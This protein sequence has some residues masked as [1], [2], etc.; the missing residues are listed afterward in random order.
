MKTRIIVDAMGGD[1][2]PFSMVKGAVDGALAYGADLIFVGNKPEIEEILKT[3]PTSSLDIKV[4]HTD[5]WVE[6]SDPPT[7]V[8][9]EKRDSSVAISCDLLNDGEGDVLISSGNTGALFTAATL[10][11]RKLK[12]VRRSALGA[13]INLENPF[14]LV[15]SGAN[16]E[17]TPEILTQFAYMGSLYCR[18]MMG[19]DNPRVALI[20]NG[21]EETKGTGL[22]RETHALL[23]QTGLNFV[24][25]CETR[26]LANNFCDVAVCDGFVG[27][28][29]LKAIEGMGQFIIR[30]FK[31]IYGKNAFSKLS[32]LLIKNNIAG[33]KKQIDHREYGGAPFLGI[34]KPVIKSHGSAD[35]KS[36]MSTIKQARD[37]H[38][39]GLNEKIAE[40]VANWEK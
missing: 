9:K 6:M 37:Y 24:G 31:E 28:I 35:P 30:N 34:S 19:I 18:Y 25:N 33:F 8:K 23:K 5:V 10:F 27:N 20:N 4:V 38:Q 11:I 26:D 13:V 36:I 15:D 1:N 16:I 22:Y 2:A 17:V 40:G 29:T 3:L 21:A 32:Y 14:I 7:S 12:G 39:S